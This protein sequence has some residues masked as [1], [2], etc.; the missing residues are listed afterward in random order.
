[1]STSSNEAAAGAPE[2]AG[3]TAAARAA[4]AV[5]IG[6]VEQLIA[7]REARSWSAADVAA[8]LGMMP[9]QIEAIER[10][11]WGTLPG[12]AFVRGA[13]RAY[14]KALQADVEPL[15]ASVG[16][17]VSAPVLRPAASLEA[18]LPRHGALG[19]DSGGS[20]SRLTWILLAV[21]GVVAIALYFGRGGELARVLEG[22]APAATPGHNV[23][24]VPV[25]PPAPSEPASS[26]SAPASSPSAPAG[27][28]SLAPAPGVPAQAGAAPAA[29][30]GSAAERSPAKSGVIPA[31]ASTAAQSPGA[32]A[33][34]DASAANAAAA[35]LLEANA[36]AAKVRPGAVANAIDVANLAAVSAPAGQEGGPAAAAPGVL[37]FRFE[38]ESWVDVRDA[39]GSVLLHGTQPAQSTREVGG[40]RPYV[41]VVGNAEH[42]RLEH[43]GRSVDLAGLAR[44]GV[45]RLTIR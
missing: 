26:P 15:L 7:A 9:R 10:G 28:S 38:G 39:T 17:E 33:P 27:S 40:K 14:G 44:Q 20:G 37:R 6:T 42:V 13:I 41:L 11:D 45:A 43:D 23:E 19:F 2:A 3:E 35:G 29:V 32:G 18:P 8:K 1:M 24:T 12:Q 25:Q 31:A 4:G 30:Q 34:G 5:A 16:R 36:S 21:L 22:G